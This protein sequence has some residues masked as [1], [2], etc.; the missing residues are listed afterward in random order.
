MRFFYMFEKV[1][2]GTSASGGIFFVHEGP[3]R[4]CEP[5]RESENDIGEVQHF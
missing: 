4:A 3:N 2:S 1:M 5:V